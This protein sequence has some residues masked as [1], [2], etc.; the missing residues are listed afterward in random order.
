MVLSRNLIH[1]WLENRDPLKM[2]FLN[3]GLLCELFHCKFVVKSS[4]R[5]AAGAF[6]APMSCAEKLK[7]SC[8]CDQKRDSWLLEYCQGIDGNCLTS[9]LVTNCGS[10][11]FAR[12]RY[13][14]MV[15]HLLPI[16]FHTNKSDDCN[17]IIICS[18]ALW[19]PHKWLFSFQTV[20]PINPMGK[21]IHN[22]YRHKQDSSGK[23]LI[24]FGNPSPNHGHLFFPLEASSLPRC[25]VG[26]MDEAHASTCLI[27][28]S[29][30]Q[31]FGSFGIPRIYLYLRTSRNPPRLWCLEDVS[32]FPNGFVTICILE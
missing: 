14:K 6:L 31:S 3:L 21:D 32:L 26:A 30:L 20:A 27:L 9:S 13:P 23:A 4:S 10:V 1:S 11:R 16:D 24:W 15:K 7:R 28:V 8:V 25:S 2:R 22:T 18:V 29:W 5:R 19:E 17:R 12:Q